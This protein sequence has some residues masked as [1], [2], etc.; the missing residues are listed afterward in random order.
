M[1]F[2]YIIES[3]ISGKWYYGF[4]E[5]PEERL[6]EHNGNHHHYT[7]GKGPWILIFI[8]AFDLQN[9]AVLFEKKLKTLRNKEFIKSEF[10]EFFLIR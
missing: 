5:R 2:V 6:K 3:E 9:E 7:A 4:T 8:R 10:K 1:Y